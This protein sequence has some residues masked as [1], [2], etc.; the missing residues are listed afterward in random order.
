[1]VL[2][3]TELWL[4]FKTLTLGQAVEWRMLLLYCF[5]VSPLPKKFSFFVYSAFVQFLIFLIFHTHQALLG[6]R[7]DLLR[8]CQMDSS[9]QSHPC[10]DPGIQL[11]IIMYFYHAL[12]NALSTHMIHINLNMIFYTHV[13][14]SPTKTIYIK[15]LKNPQKRTTNTHAHTQTHTMTV[16]ETGY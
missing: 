7:V 1:M 6:A 11:I 2:D 16:A 5:Y 8:P 3:S 4:I 14:H 15:F 12:I 10:L 13:E 9:Q